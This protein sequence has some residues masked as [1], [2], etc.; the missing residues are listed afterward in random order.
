M[1]RNRQEEEKQEKAS[2]NHTQKVLLEATLSIYHA[3]IFRLGFLY[4]I[5][6]MERIINDKE[7]T[8]SE[9]D[10]LTQ[11]NV[12]DSVELIQKIRFHSAPQNRYK[13]CPYFEKHRDPKLVI[14]KDDNGQR[15]FETRGLLSLSIHNDANTHVTKQGVIDHMNVM[16]KKLMEEKIQ[17][18]PEY[19][20]RFYEALMNNNAPAL[21]AILEINPALSNEP[22]DN[23]EK[24]SPLLCAINNNNYS[25]EIVKILL[26][27]G[28][29]IESKN[30]KGQTALFFAVF[31]GRQNCIT[32]LLERGANKDHRDFDNKTIVDYINAA[33]NQNHH[34]PYESKS[35]YVENNDPTVV[36]PSQERFFRSSDRL[37][38][39]NVKRM[40]ETAEILASNGLSKE[41][42]ISVW[43]EKYKFTRNHQK[44]LIHLVFEQR[45]N[46]ADALKIIC[47][48][49]T[50]QEAKSLYEDLQN[51]SGYSMRIS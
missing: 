12:I 44:A 17:G 29:D 26:E 33:N 30:A 8:E 1:F 21:R 47:A 22:Y 39:A 27:F 6:I 49:P 11:L 25:D 4:A 7:F 40:Q 2:I 36:G 16:M 20:H 14:F 48:F 45:Q 10:F 34:E 37:R 28:A 32:M 24:L 51:Q 5:P 18:H 15:S 43:P 38:K 42:L 9:K 41:W 31:L 19:Y 3:D 35:D 46:I 23:E 50:E 13:D